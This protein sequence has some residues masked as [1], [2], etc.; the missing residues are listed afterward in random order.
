MKWIESGMV[1]SLNN[2]LPLSGQQI[3]EFYSHPVWLMN[4]VFTCVDLESENHRDSIAKYIIKYNNK[5]IADYG[6]GFGE[7]ALKIAQESGQAVVKII[8]PFPSQFGSYRLAN[9]EQIKLINDLGKKEYDVIIAQDV[10]EHVEDPIGLAANLT[11]SVRHNGLIIFA[12]CFYPVIK[13]HLPATFHLRH[14][15]ILIMKMYGLNFVG[16]IPGASHA[17][18]F[19]KS[20]NLNF[21]N[22]RKAEKIIRPVGILL[23]FAKNLASRMKKTFINNESST[24][25]HFRYTGGGG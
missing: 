20:R 11:E 17:L 7:L 6:G 19:K 14:T 3:G 9:H 10:L 18:V 23:N 12:N 21:N 5:F 16:R 15:F 22:A 13:C 4:G 8:E 24:S 1:F 2:K 25:K